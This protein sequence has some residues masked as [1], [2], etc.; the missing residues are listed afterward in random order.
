MPNTNDPALPGMQQVV[1]L[2]HVNAARPTCRYCTCRHDAEDSHEIDGETYCPECVVQCV[3]CTTVCSP[4]GTSVTPA[5]MSYSSGEAQSL[6]DCCA[7]ECVDCHVRFSASLDTYHNPRGDRI[8]ERC[9]SHYGGCESCPGY[10]HEDN[11]SY[12]EDTG[13]TLCQVCRE[14]QEDG[15]ETILHDYSYVPPLKYNYGRNE[16]RSSKSSLLFCG[17]EFEVDDGDA[18]EVQSTISSSGLAAHSAFYCKQ[19]GSLNTGFEVVSHPGTFK[20]WMEHDFTW[21]ELVRKSGFKSYNTKTCGQHFH[22][23]R[24]WFTQLDILKLLTFFRDESD[25]IVKMSRRASKKAME[26]W[27]AIDG[28]K[29]K[30]HCYMAKGP[31][32]YSEKLYP[33][34]ASNRYSNHSKH[35]R[36][37]ALNLEPRRTIEFRF[38]RGTLHVPSIKRN[39]S[40]VFALCYFVK[41]ES[42]ANMNLGAFR[43]WISDHGK[44]CIGGKVS[45]DLLMWISGQTAVMEV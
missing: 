15:E 34:L 1:D 28:S 38:F 27:A 7:F 32:V 33:H 14:H 37:S 41:E 6:C 8:C 30:L 19:D 22:V 23:T 3:E 39:I 9:S 4:D 45:H 17:G 40:L 18:E 44:E 25:F 13:T 5:F 43:Q 31:K 12:Y 16:K 36:Y 35:G 21:A 26:A 24:G 10:F 11:L 42:L 29:R 2:E 20:W